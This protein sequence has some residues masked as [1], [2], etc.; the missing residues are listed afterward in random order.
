MSELHL[1]AHSPCSESGP[2]TGVVAPPLSTPPTAVCLAF[3][4]PVGS[5][6]EWKALAKE[7][8]KPGYSV[9]LRS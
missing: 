9:Q 4:L 8:L 1:R 2:A 3:M 5:H 7:R 6:S